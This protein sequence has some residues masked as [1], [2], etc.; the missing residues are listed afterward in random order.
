MN[1]G[2]PLVGAL[3]QFWKIFQIGHPQGVPLHNKNN[4][5]MK[6]NS[7]FSLLEILITLAII[8]LLS[9]I[10]YP[11]YTQHVTQTHR[12]QAQ[13]ALFNLANQMERYYVENN[14]SYAQATLAKLGFDETTLKD[15]YEISITATATTYKLQAMPLK[16]QAKHDANCGSLVLN[17]LGEKKITGSGSLQECW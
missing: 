14:H 6:K 1:V 11:L 7:G 9:A 4:K 10:A 13:I 16:N 8:S 5:F 12:K 3:I 17:Q 15:R 2:A